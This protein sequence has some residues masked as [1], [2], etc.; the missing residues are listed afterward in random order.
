MRRPWD[1]LQNWFRR[2]SPPPRPPVLPPPWIDAPDAAESVRR[3]ARGDALLEAVGRDI[4]E[5]GF[6]ILRGVVPPERCDGAVRD[7]AKF[8]AAH[9]SDGQFRDRQGRYLRLVNLHL[10]SEHCRAIG[11][12]PTVMRVLDFLF[13]AKACIYTSL[14][15]EYG[16]QQ[17]L[18]RD[19]PFFETFPRNYFLGVWVALEDID[20]ASGPL[21]YVPRG[22]RF[23]CDPHEIYRARRARHPDLP[24]R[25]I[26]EACLQDY[27]GAIT[28]NCAALAEPV[29]VALKKGD[30]AFWHPAAPHGGSPAA[31]PELTRRSIVFHCAPE[32]AQVYQQDVFF[33]H[34][35]ARPPPPR[36]G[37]RRYG[38][39][40]VALAGKTAFQ[41]PDE[42]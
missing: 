40:K 24:E 15:F 18:H 42:G 4:V 26:V 31:R 34:H 11:L 37:F 12:H 36:Y 25:Q 38:D 21:M 29:K 10:A 7:F 8:A 41:V 1:V 17:P 28:R 3:R 20:P 30:V 6:A 13:G 22:H 33:A 16:T 23:A 35:A 39:R 2:W 14:Y 19:S 32:A 27:Y 9:A 5:S